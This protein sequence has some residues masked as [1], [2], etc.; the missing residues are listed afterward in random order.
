MHA[1]GPP[2]H[3]RDYVGHRA[4]CAYVQGFCESAARFRNG[5]GHRDQ[6]G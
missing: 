4:N 1:C 6:I 2:F 3:F 5:V